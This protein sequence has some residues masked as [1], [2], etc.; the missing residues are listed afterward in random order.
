[1]PISRTCRAKSGEEKQGCIADRA[2]EQTWP[3]SCGC[4]GMIIVIHCGSAY[5]YAYCNAHE[6]LFWFQEEGEC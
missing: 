4:L 3:L 2:D 6:R 1:M 5:A